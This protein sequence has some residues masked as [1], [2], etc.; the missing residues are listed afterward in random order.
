MRVGEGIETA[1]LRTLVF[2]GPLG[3]ADEEALVR[4]EPVNG[5]EVLVLRGVFPGDIGE[6]RAAEVGYIFAA[7]ELG[8][9]VNVV[10]DDVGGKLLT[11]AIAPV[12]EFIRSSKFFPSSLVPQSLRLPSALN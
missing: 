9:D 4:G 1:V 6:E 8:V 10:N 3:I 5:L 11:L 2:A 7:G 12:F